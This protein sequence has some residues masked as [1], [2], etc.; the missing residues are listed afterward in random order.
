MS[1]M[2]RSLLSKLVSARPNDILVL[3]STGFTGRLISEYL[4]GFNGVKVVLAGRSAEKLAALSN[5]LL[6]I[7]GGSWPNH[8]PNFAILPSTE[9][10]SALDELVSSAKASLNCRR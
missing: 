9:A 10:S 7:H 8:P 3:G 5:D 6:V 4:T 2:N 1:A